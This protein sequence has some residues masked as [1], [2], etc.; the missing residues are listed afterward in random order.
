MSESPRPFDRLDYTYKLLVVISLTI[1]A[2]ILARDIF[3]PMIFAGLLSIVMLPVVKKLEDKRV[4]TSLA[5]T[6][7]LLVTVVIFVLLL[8][9]VISQVVNLVDDLPDLQARFENYVD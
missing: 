8:W 3:I 7:V 9:L 1:T 4:P 6:I 5:I 2:V